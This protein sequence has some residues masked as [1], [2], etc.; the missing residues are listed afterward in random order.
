LD[1]LLAS[2][3]VLAYSIC[4][5]LDLANPSE[6]IMM[7]YPWISSIREKENK[8]SHGFAGA[9]SPWPCPYS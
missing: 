8:D 2:K 9:C 6:L 1:W 4:P 5:F 7:K 3:K